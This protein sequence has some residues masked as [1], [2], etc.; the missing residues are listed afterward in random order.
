MSRQTTD[1][2]QD[3]LHQHWLHVYN[4]DDFPMDFATDRYNCS[5]EYVRTVMRDIEKANPKPKNRN[6]DTC[7]KCQ[8]PIIWIG[9]HACEE[10]ILEVVLADE[11]LHSGRIPHVCQQFSGQSGIEAAAAE[12]Q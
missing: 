12:G 11:T 2:K 5:A 7:R 10:A 8:Q 4:W 3:M 9:K 6:A 1:L